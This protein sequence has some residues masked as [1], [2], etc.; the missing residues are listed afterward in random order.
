MWENA[1]APPCATATQPHSGMILLAT[2]DEHVLY[3]RH[4]VFVIGGTCAT[5]NF[6]LWKVKDRNDVYVVTHRRVLPAGI[7]SDYIHAGRQRSIPASG[8]RQVDV[9]SQ[10]DHVSL[11]S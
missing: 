2:K 1:I 10:T 8:W 11:V 6:T 3:I 7:W 9:R 5:V 4:G